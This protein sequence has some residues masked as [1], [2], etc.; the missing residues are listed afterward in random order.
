M[1]ELRIRLAAHPASV[2]GARRFVTDS[3][4]SW[5]LDALADDAELCVSELAGNAA[6]HSSS[7]FMEVSLLRRPASVRLSVEDEGATPAA[8]VHPRVG[9]PGPFTQ[10]AAEDV[11]HEATTGRG[12]AI[13]SI[14]ASDWGVEVTDDGKRVWA[15][16]TAESPESAVRSP[17]VAAGAAPAMPAAPAALPSGWI[18]VRLLSCPVALSIRQDDHLDELVRELQLLEGDVGNLRS[19]DLARQLEGLLAGP[20]HAR[21]TGRRAA[22]LAAAAGHT[23]L[24]VEMAM[25]RELALTVQQLQAT[26]M[27]ADAL[28][29]QAR[30]LTL[31][32]PPELRALRA[33]MTEQ[34]TA[35]ADGAEPVPWPAWLSVHHPAMLA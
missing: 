31:A 35:Q 27:A 12:L 8:A 17:S 11:E 15:E 33:W 28:C 14:L 25:P 10:V 20:A 34:L 2:P 32:S 19:R 6:L 4:R 23:E 1:D 30:L 7:A 5:Q 18:L 29:E 26:V 3:L 13:V 16:L 9:F 24:D 22:Q 21:H